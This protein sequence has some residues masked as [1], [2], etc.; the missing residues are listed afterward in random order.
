MS[1][2]SQ[3]QTKGSGKTLSDKQ[4]IMRAYKEVSKPKV[5]NKFAGMAARVERLEPVIIPGYK[6]RG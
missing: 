4:S 6:I 2:F 3:K 5:V 1:R